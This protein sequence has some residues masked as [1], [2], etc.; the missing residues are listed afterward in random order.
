MI[1][2]PDLL[3]RI[4]N[5]S[6]SLGVPPLTS[7]LPEGTILVDLATNIGWPAAVNRGMEIAIDQGVDWTLILNND[8]TVTSDCLARCLDEALLHDKTA[9]VGPAI[10]FQEHPDTLWFAGGKVNA[11]FAFTMHRG[12]LQPTSGKPPSSRTDFVSGCC[13]IVSSKAWRSIGP[14]REDYFAYYEDAEWCQR[15]A[16]EGWQCRYVGDVLCH[17]KV[18]A[19]WS[20][21]G[22]LEISPGMAYYL[23]RN[24]LRFALETK[25]TLKRVTRIFGIMA[26]WNAYFAWRA[27]KSR[28]AQL[29]NAYVQ[30][31][32]DAVRG[33]MG[34]RPLARST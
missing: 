3:I 7:S 9:A 19:T 29:A 32:R 24:P 18:S 27:L 2:P 6:M 23:A 21:P 33:R 16:A 1:P 34:R 10:V 12:L 26:I 25:P 31:L 17:H 4:D 5:N 30:G 28:N 13:F 20:R 22:S 8:A 11:W 14:F 15:A